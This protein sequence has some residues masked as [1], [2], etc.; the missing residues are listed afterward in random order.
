MHR[1]RWTS[2]A[3]A[4]A[5]LAVV[6]VAPG[7]EP[8]TTTALPDT[9][10]AHDWAVQSQGSATDAQAPV[11]SPAP[12]PPPNGCRDQCEPGSPDDVAPGTCAEDDPCWDCATMGNRICGPIREDASSITFLPDTAI[13]PAL[14]QPASQLGS[15]GL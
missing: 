9:A 15:G 3:M 1:T 12:L 7:D 2:W 5:V 14:T 6:A 10:I 11:P 13:R 8:P 4:L